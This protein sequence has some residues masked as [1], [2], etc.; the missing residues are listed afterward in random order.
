MTITKIF[1]VADAFPPVLGIFCLAL[2]LLAAL[3]FPLIHGKGKGAE[4]P[5]KYLYSLVAYGVCASGL[6]WAIVPAYI[7]TFSQEPCPDVRPIWFYWPGIVMILTL[8][9]IARTVP[10]NSIPGLKRLYLIIPIIAVSLF[11]PLRL[12]KGELIEMGLLKFIALAFPIFV[13][14]QSV[15]WVSFRA[16]T[17]AKVAEV[18][19]APKRQ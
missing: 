9:Q 19:E 14:L 6:Y 5:W 2:P 18:P 11:I 15:V 12:E 3:V 4:A 16:R 10:F 13:V 17:K 8:I 7:L 1:Q